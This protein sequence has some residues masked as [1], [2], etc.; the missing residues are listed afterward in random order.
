LIIFL[1]LETQQP[2]TVPRP[3]EMQI[4][5]TLAF[6]EWIWTETREMHNLYIERTWKSQEYCTLF[7][8]PLFSVLFFIIFIIGG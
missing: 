7:K 5:E 3:D 2:D 1:R 4:H 8:F 6:Q